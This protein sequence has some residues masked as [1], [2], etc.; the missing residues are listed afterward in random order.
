MLEHGD[1]PYRN[2]WFLVKKK[3]KS[4]RLINPAIDMNRV[5]IRDTNMLPSLDKFAEGFDS[6]QMASM[7]DFFSGYDQVELDVGSRDMTVFQ[8]PLGLL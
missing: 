8:T 4:Y 7:I 5:T 1:G 2:S 6:C 3:S